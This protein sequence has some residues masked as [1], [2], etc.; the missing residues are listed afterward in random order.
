LVVLDYNLPDL[1]GWKLHREIRK[2]EK[3]KKIPVLALITRLPDYMIDLS[4]K[5]STNSLD[6]Y[7]TLPFGEEFVQ[8]TKQLLRQG[9]S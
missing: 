2:D 8:K 4:L 9:V 3:L 5:P 6:D 1:A 7:V